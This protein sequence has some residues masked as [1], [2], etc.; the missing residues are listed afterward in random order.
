MHQDK[1]KRRG[2]L[3]PQLVVRKTDLQLKCFLELMD[4]SAPD[5]TR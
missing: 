4:R 5:S 1:E 3:N 2:K